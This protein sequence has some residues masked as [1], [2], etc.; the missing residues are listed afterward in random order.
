MCYVKSVLQCTEPIG[1]ANKF[2]YVLRLRLLEQQPSVVF[3]Y[4]MSL[5]ILVACR[6][7]FRF[8]ELFFSYKFRR[9]VLM[10][11]IMNKEIF[12]LPT[13][14]LFSV[15]GLPMFLRSRKS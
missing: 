10:Q 2:G 11:Q 1:V 4:L 3:S 9:K 12:P 7:Y 6:Y 5:S 15:G 13:K 14:L 8:V